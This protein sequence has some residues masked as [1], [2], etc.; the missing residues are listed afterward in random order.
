MVVSF[1]I[2]KQTCR[3]VNLYLINESYEQ[4]SCPRMSIDECWFLSKNV[5]WWGLIPVQECQLMR[6]DSCPRMSID[7]DWFLSKNVNWWVLIWSYRTTHIRRSTWCSGKCFSLVTGGCLSVVSSNSINGL[8]CFHET[9][10]AWVSVSNQ[11]THCFLNEKRE[12]ETHIYQYVLDSY[13]WSRWGYI[14]TCTVFQTHLWILVHSFIGILQLCLYHAHITIYY[15]RRIILFNVN[16]KYI[17]W[18][19]WQINGR[20]GA[21]GCMSDS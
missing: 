12:Y 17:L 8:W 20:R 7:E 2:M 18:A 15:Y 9:C 14:T 16:I 19:P 3:G 13:L 5:N 6:V 11:H 10:S 21:V 4:Q 1:L